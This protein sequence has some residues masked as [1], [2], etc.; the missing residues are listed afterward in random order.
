MNIVSSYNYND[1][2]IK[3][4]YIYQKGG[5]KGARPHFTFRECSSLLAVTFENGIDSIYTENVPYNQ[6]YS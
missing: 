2:F 4:F 5:E 3:K 6:N 1:W